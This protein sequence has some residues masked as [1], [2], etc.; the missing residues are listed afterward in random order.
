MFVDL[1][2]RYMPDPFVLAIGL[3]AFTAFLALL[4]APKCSPTLIVTSW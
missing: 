2:E 3:T 1:F 4:I